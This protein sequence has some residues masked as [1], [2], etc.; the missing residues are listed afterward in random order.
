[1]CVNSLWGKRKKHKISQTEKNFKNTQF[2]SILK[3][4]Q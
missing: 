1:M 4:N 3:I 2:F